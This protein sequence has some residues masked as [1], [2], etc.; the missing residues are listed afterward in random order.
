MSITTETPITGHRPTRS[1]AE[2]RLMQAVASAVEDE[3][4]IIQSA[5]RW[6]GWYTWQTG[7]DLP[8]DLFIK[9]VESADYLGFAL[10][11]G[12][13]GESLEAQAAVEHYKGACMAIILGRIL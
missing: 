11:Y 2:E 6:H 13:P 1:E 5:P 12:A 8:E 9:L 3:G 10:G 4:G 7:I